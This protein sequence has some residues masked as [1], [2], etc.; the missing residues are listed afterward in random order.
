MQPYII[1]TTHYINR[2]YN[3]VENTNNKTMLH[4]L[5]FAIK[6]IP[7]DDCLQ[8]MRKNTHNETNIHATNL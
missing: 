7:N 2:H 3:K 4:Q 8:R 5:H 1:V 6:Q